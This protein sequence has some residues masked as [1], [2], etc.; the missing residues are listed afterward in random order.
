MVE[1]VYIVLMALGSTGAGL[2][3]LRTVGP[4][5][6]SRAEELVFSIGVGLGCLALC[7]MFLGLLGL[8]F[9]P[10]FYVLLL[11]GLLLGRKQLIGMAGRLQGRLA[12]RSL[13]WDSFSLCIVVFVG[14]AL[15]LNLLRALMPPHGAVDP[16]AYHLALPNIYLIKHYLS[17][18]QTLTGSLYPDNIGMLYTAA[19][20]LR[21]ASLAQVVHWFMGAVTVMAIWCFCRDYFNSQVGVFAAAIYAFTPVFIFFSPLAYVDVGVALFQFLSLWALFKWMREGGDRTL[22]LV[23]IFTGLAMGSKHTALFLGMASS[24]AIFLRL[25]KLKEPPKKMARSLFL[26]GGVA[27]LLAMPWYLR[28]L[29]YAGNP[30]W[31]VANELFGGLPYGSN[32]SIAMP[33]VVETSGLQWERIKDLAYVAATSLWEWAWNGQLGWQRATGIYYLALPPVALF[34]WR[35]ARLRWLILGSALYYLMVVLYVDGNPRYNLAFFALLSI[36]AG[37]VAQRFSAHRI[38][39]LRLLFNSTFLA[40]LL[41]GL[42]QSYALAYPAVHFTLSRQDSEQFLLATEGNYKAFSF[43]NRQLPPDAKVLLQGIVKGYYCQREYMWD[44][45]YQ[46][47]LQYGEY[48]TAEQML[49]RMKELRITHIVRMIHIPPGRINFFPQYFTDSKHEEFRKK[50]LKLLYRDNGYVVFEISYP[51]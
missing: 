8:L 10:V 3:L 20:G 46:R 41:C 16:L 15:A 40:T 42:A 14:L 23:G 51:S 31:P 24:L 6:T 45:P 33:S 11:A 9:E 13:A 48:A 7:T 1:L 29:I 30:V 25:L 4:T 27:L 38:R 2:A 28:A 22:L 44:H 39:S 19:I 34:H 17:F 49:E 35:R 37:W 47:L 36:L 50:F 12:E 43:V 5:S 26:F 21:G 32:F 18:E